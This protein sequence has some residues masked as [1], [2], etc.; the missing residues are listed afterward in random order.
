MLWCWAQH[1]PTT[2]CQAAV[3]AWLY[4]FNKCRKPVQ[5]DNTV[6]ICTVS[7]R[8]HQQHFP[9]KSFQ[10][11]AADYGSRVLS[12]FISPDSPEY[13]IVS[14][15][16]TVSVP[17]MVFN[18]QQNF[19]FREDIYIQC[20][21]DNREGV[22]GKKS[23]PLGWNSHLSDPI[24]QGIVTPVNFQVL[25]LHKNPACEVSHLSGEHCRCHFGS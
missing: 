18:L 17:K 2:S 10:V 1:N 23:V 12:S 4:D 6:S 13:S 11:K 15:Y 3:D 14:I 9:L 20:S 19:T 5:Q 21:I 8:D 24:L 22:G 25:H 7:N 16:G